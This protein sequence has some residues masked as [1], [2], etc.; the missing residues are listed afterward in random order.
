[1]WFKALALPGASFICKGPFWFNSSFC[2]SLNWQSGVRGGVRG[3]PL[4]LLKSYQTQGLSVC[5]FEETETL[6]LQVSLQHSEAA[7]KGDRLLK[8]GLAGW[9]WGG[10]GSVEKDRCDWTHLGS[11][12]RSFLPGLLECDFLNSDWPSF[13]SCG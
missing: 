10:A 6:S 4:G 7:W 1:M 12:H 11:A 2:G 5:R 3:L 9:G 8:S 13:F